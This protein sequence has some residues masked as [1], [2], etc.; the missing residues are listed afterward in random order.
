MSSYSTHSACSRLVRQD[1]EFFLA[2]PPEL[3]SPPHGAMLLNKDYGNSTFYFHYPHITAVGDKFR[4]AL[5]N[6][7]S[8]KP[9]RSKTSSCTERNL[10]Q[11]MH[12]SSHTCEVASSS[13]E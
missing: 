10:T 5:A 1:D 8:G 3:T 6:A 2:R 13:R 7:S 12:H 4:D 11:Q 9:H